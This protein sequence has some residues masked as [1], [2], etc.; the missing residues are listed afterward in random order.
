[1]MSARIVGVLPFIT[2]ISLICSCS[3]TKKP[4]AE[5]PPP[6]VTVAAPIL[7][8]VTQYEYFTGRTEAIQKVEIR[9]KV[10]GYL[11]EIYFD[12]GTEVT[13]NKLL[14][15]ID[16]EPFNVALSQ[17]EAEAGVLQTRLKRLTDEVARMEPGRKT[18][19]VSINEFEKSLGDK[20]ET[21]ANLEVTKAKIEDAK[22]N[23]KYAKIN[24]PINGRIGDKLVTKGN[25][26]MGGAG[27]TTLLTTILSVDPI[28]VAFD[29]DENTLQR[30]QAAIRSGKLTPKEHNE[31]TVQLGLAIDENEY[32]M[33]GKVQFIDNQVDPTTGTI[34]FKAEF[35]NPKDGLKG[36][37]LTPGMYARV[38]I[39]IGAPQSAVLIPESAIG[40]DQST[41]FIYLIGDENKAVRV[42]VQLGIQD[43]DMRVIE[44][45]QVNGSAKRP[46]TVNDKVVINGLQRVRPGLVVEPSS[47]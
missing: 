23:I 34:R 39:P 14:F 4:K 2:F 40:S 15:E 35:A 42:N 46:L 8:E 12:A 22:L 45:I 28:H 3:E 41:K 6:I 13:E 38:R 17:M 26:V 31:I 20:N 47:K 27:N 9:A 43:G 32:P 44:S 18:G 1:M 10:T 5:L 37:V 33:T 16:P 24:S 21:A 36:R 19:A 29:M 7:K 11:K 25:L 30:L